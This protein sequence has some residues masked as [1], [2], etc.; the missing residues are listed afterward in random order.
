MAKTTAGKIFKSRWL[1]GVGGVILGALIILVIRFATYKP[2]AVHY[3]ANFAVYINGQREQFKSPRYYEETAGPSCSS[4]EHSDDP[5]ERAHMHMPVND[6]VHVHD[7][8]VT[9]GIFFQNLGWALGNDYI[10]TV[11]QYYP[12]DPQHQLTFILNGKKINGAANRVIGDED[13]LLIN[14][15]DQSTDQLQA[16]YKAIPATAHKYDVSK[17]TA[18]CGAKTTPTFHDRLSHLF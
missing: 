3:H 16:E 2:D 10:H 15:G 13:K 9:W 5:A 14:Y 12:A 1:I 18:A 4:E 6:V 8:A 11:D 7:H 17:D